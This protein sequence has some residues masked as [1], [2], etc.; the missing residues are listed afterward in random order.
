MRLAITGGTGLVGRFIVNEALAAGDMVTVLCRTAPRPDFFDAPVRH[1]PYDLAAPPP[2]LRGFDAVIHAAFAHV[3]GRYRGGEGD[4]PDGFLARNLDGSLR[5]FAASAAAGL[6]VVFLSSRAVY[7]P[8]DGVLTED[9]TC[10]PDTLYGQAKLRAE[11]ELLGSGA[12]AMVLRAT[13]V[14]GTPGP[15]QRHK[16]AGL[17]ADFA[18]RRPITPRVGTEIHGGDLAAAVRL[19]LSGARGVFNVSDLLLDRRELLTL[20]RQMS[21]QDGIIP[22]AADGTAF[23]QMATERLCAL[24]WRPGGRVRLTQTLRQIAADAGFGATPA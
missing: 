10:R 21:G 24:G 12:P 16:W 20:W 8:Q 5:L 18:A 7:G 1:I 11:Q 14:Y 13:G 15:G 2:D 17:F 9:L 4:D 6:P 3:P 22:A 19:G 23:N